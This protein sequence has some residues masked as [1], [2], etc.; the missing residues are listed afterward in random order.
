MYTLHVAADHMVLC[1]I[2]ISTWITGRKKKAFSDFH[3]LLIFFFS[4]FIYHSVLL[5]EVLT[6][7]KI[8]QIEKKKKKKKEM[9]LRNDWTDEYT[10]VSQK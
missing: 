1:K 6:F 9:M 10:L 8:V 2:F 4:N 3:R 7:L 5:S